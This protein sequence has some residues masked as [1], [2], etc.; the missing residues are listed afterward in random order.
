MIDVIQESIQVAARFGAQLGMQLE[1]DRVIGEWESYSNALKTDLNTSRQQAEKYLAL[2]RHYEQQIV[3]KDAKLKSAEREL[4]SRFDELQKEKQKFENMK[5]SIQSQKKQS[6]EDCDNL[7]KKCKKIE[8]QLFL[9]SN[10]NKLKIRD[11]SKE[12]NKKNCYLLATRARL[13]GVERVY[14]SLL[15]EIFMNGEV[16]RYQALQDDSRKKV[17]LTSWN[18][19][20]LARSEYTPSLHFSYESLPSF[21]S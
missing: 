6:V 11:L 14:G 17:L 20:V 21:I 5:S 15:S 8:N 18:D 7:Q 10:Q 16:R 19:V 12:L 4:K 13:V 9:L 3:E 2:S 1:F